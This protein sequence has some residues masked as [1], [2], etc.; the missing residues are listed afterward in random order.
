[1]WLLLVDSTGNAALVFQTQ[2]S[3]L[4]YRFLSDV[5]IKFFAL[6]FF[7][8]EL[9]LLLC[10][11]L[12]FCEPAFMAAKFFYF[13]EQNFFA[14]RWFTAFST[15]FLIFSGVGGVFLS[16]LILLKVVLSRFFGTKHSFVP[17]QFKNS[18]LLPTVF[19]L[20]FD[21]NGEKM[22]KFLFDFLQFIALYFDNREVSVLTAGCNLAKT[23]SSRVW[24]S[25]RNVVWSVISLECI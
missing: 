3:R 7:F 20:I 16:F 5:V 6:F 17:A 14:L 23:S 25:S 21:E 2:I 11:C 12:S 15:F 24:N 10:F 19:P 4:F 22:L 13:N 1:M 8:F 9:Y 18:S